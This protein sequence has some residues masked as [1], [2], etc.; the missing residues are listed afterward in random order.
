MKN[1]SQTKTDAIRFISLPVHALVLNGLQDRVNIRKQR[2]ELEVLLIG[3]YTSVLSVRQWSV[4]KPLTALQA[5][6]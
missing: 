2:Q 3:S 4:Q 5:E 1:A 6:E